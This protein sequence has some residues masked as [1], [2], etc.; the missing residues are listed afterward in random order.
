MSNENASDDISLNSVQDRK[1]TLN[2]ET[3][4]SNPI[5]N[6]SFLSS[7]YSNYGPD[8]Q[9]TSREQIPPRKFTS[10]RT[11]QCFSDENFHFY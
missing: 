1:G 7:S 8:Q 3:P 6:N 10:Q 5:R 11:H 2:N 9:P 4:D